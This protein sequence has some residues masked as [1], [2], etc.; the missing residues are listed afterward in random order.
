M[1]GGQHMPDQANKMLRALLLAGC[2][3]AAAMLATPALAQSAAKTTEEMERAQRD[4]DKV[5]KMILINSD[6]PRKKRAPEASAGAGTPA[7]V[8]SVSV[9]TTSNSPE[10]IA[11]AAAV[12]AARAAEPAKVAAAPAAAVAAEPEARVAIAP[13]VAQ[14]APQSAAAVLAPAAPASTPAA[15]EEEDDDESPLVLRSQVRPS[16]RPALMQELR[17]GTVR[18]KFEVQPDG[19]VTRPEVVST[20]NRGLNSAA[21]AAI[22]QWKFEPLK[23]PRQAMVEVGFN[24]DN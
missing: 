11:A 23:Q 7:P 5:F 4:A 24:A 12:A 19:S 13:Q 17:Q 15:A 21:L 1:Q 18:V 2:A 3:S 10:A 22:G 14:P 16:F 6:A 20:T 8:R 9:A